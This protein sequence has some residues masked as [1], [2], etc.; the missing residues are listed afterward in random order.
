M[1]RH[2][3]PAQGFP[4]MNHGA[5]LLLNL[6]PGQTVQPLTLIQCRPPHP[7]QT[8]INNKVIGLLSPLIWSLIAVISCP[9]STFAGSAGTAK[10]RRVSC[11]RWPGGTDQ[12]GSSRLE[13]PRPAGLHLY[14]YAPACHANHP[15]RDTRTRSVTADMYF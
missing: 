6:Q 2:V 1:S 5:R 14:H 9:R 11:A 13:R 15:H 4:V 8:S 10:R 7:H 3:F 12:D